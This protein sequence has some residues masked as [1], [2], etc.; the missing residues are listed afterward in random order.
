ML[1]QYQPPLFACFLVIGAAACFN[2]AHART[3]FVSPQGIPGSL[4]TETQPTTIAEAFSLAS[5]PEIREIALLDGE[6]FLEAPLKL[7]IQRRPETRLSVRA[8]NPGKAVLSGGFPLENPSA[9]ADGDRIAFALPNDGDLAGSRDLYLG[10]LRATRARSI[11]YA[12]WL[13][14]FSAI[15]GLSKVD[16]SSP[17]SLVAIEPGATILDHSGQLPPLDGWTDPSTLEFVFRCAWWEKRCG[18]AEVS[19]NQI[20]FAEP[21]WSIINT[22]WGDEGHSRLNAAMPKT[23]RLE[24]AYELLDSPGEWHHGGDSVILIPLPGYDPETFPARL[25]KLETILRLDN[26]SHIEFS[27]VAFRHT[28]WKLPIA[29]DGF[30]EGQANFEQAGNTG[31]PAEAVAIVDSV[32]ITFSKCVF[33]Q[34]GGLGIT[35]LG[36]SCDI[37]IQSCELIDIGGSAIVIGSI[38]KRAAT[39]EIPHVSDVQ[40]QDCWIHE[41]ASVYQGGVGIFVGFASNVRLMKNEVCHSPYTGISVGWGW[42]ELVGQTTS[43][44]DNAVLENYV[45][46]HLYDMYDGGGIYTLGPQ[47]TAE[48]GIDRGLRIV[49]NVVA[50]QGGIGNILYTDGG[51]RWIELSG[52]LT[53]DNLREIDRY[54]EGTSRYNSDWGGCGPFGDMAFIGN[55]LGNARNKLPNFRCAPADPEPWNPAFK[56]PPDIVIAGNTFD[57]NPELP[58]AALQLS[59]RRHQGLDARRQPGIARIEL[60][61]ESGQSSESAFTLAGPASLS[62]E[63]SANDQPR[64]WIARVRSDAFFGDLSPLSPTIDLP[65]GRYALSISLKDDAGAAGPIALT[66]ACSDSGLRSFSTDLAEIAFAMASSPLTR[67]LIYTLGDGADRS[68]ALA[69]P[70]GSQIESNARWL[71]HPH[72]WRILRAFLDSG[73][74]PPTEHEPAILRALPAGHRYTVKRPGDS[75]A[76]LRLVAMPQRG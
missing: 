15:P 76:R 50:N 67:V 3:V 32:G 7:S 49:G 28:T 52:N 9:A 12:N 74:P 53:S 64:G 75:P 30:N 41:P 18:V 62:I 46:H 26:A 70:D 72:N 23:T 44:R 37:A 69:A 71:D 19:G 17:N 5:D 13:P 4:G 51:S 45:H 20:R 24:G 65:A 2:S 10:Q 31:R 42:N 1:R 57:E 58:A 27:G 36:E 29:T 11:E 63:T 60:A 68:V 8:E 35:V 25:G 14:E 55:A 39:G 54:Y 21:G 33:A 73:E 61:L 34:L 48:L 43:M 66:L 40:V 47:S 22:P 38:D 59:Q 6:Y 16:A 56:L